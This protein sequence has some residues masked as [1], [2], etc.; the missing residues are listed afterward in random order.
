M[1]D[2][3]KKIKI[4]KQ[5][6]TFTDYIP[7]GAEAQNISTTDGDSVQLKLN[8]KPYYYNTVADMKA[9]IKLKAKDMAITL[10]Y[11]EPNDGGAA[12]YKIIDE[13]SETDYQEELESGLYAT[14]IVKNKTLNIKQ[15]GAKGDGTADD[16]SIIEKAINYFHV[17]NDADNQNYATVL[18]RNYPD[19]GGTIYFPKGVYC[20]SSTIK[21]P[22]Y[23]D[24]DFGYSTIKAISG[25]TFTS[26]YMF[27]VNSYSLNSWTY[28][29][30][31]RKG[32][33]KNG[34]ING[35]N[36]ENIRGFYI[37]DQHKIT[38][39]E[40]YRMYNSINYAGGYYIDEVYISNCIFGYCKGTDY[41]I[42]KISQGENLQI[43][44]VGFDVTTPD[45]T[46]ANGIK[47][48][49]GHNG[50]VQNIVNGNIYLY[51][52]E[53]I[54]ID[55]WHCE[56]GFFECYPSS[57]AVIKNSNIYVRDN[58]TP[59][60]LA[61]GDD[62]NGLRSIFLEN[63]KFV[64][65][66]TLDEFNYDTK[67]IDISHYVGNIFIKGCYREQWV[68]GLNAIAQTG[69][70][71]YDG[72]N[73]LL[74]PYDECRIC[75]KK[76]IPEHK[77]VLRTDEYVFNGASVYS[78]VK[79]NLETGTY[80]YKMIN[81]ADTDRLIGRASDEKSGTITDVNKGFRININANLGYGNIVRLYRGITS[82]TYT[83]YVDIPNPKNMNLYD[84]GYS[85]GGYK[86]IAT[87]D[88]VPSV[89]SMKNVEKFDIY[90]DTLV[91]CKAYAP[92]SY[93]T[94]KQGDIVER[95][96]PSAG[97]KLGWICTT[98]GTPG[99]WKEYGTIQQ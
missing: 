3:I 55:S 21:I 45:G 37:L 50:L 22:C 63:V 70:Q 29:Y 35:N 36:I 34:Y 80:Y 72:A 41:Q 5:D 7:I 28:A 74:N 94:W 30:V 95:V 75:N 52:V 69:I 49:N 56:N 32:F 14:L 89:T 58:S 57:N 47:I 12:T 99:T 54:V 33:I 40:F 82:G 11:Y 13:E 67:D 77:S 66:L 61:A 2:L 51:N 81:F 84:N 73:Y 46:P 26:N 48:H 53:D 44:N 38:G 24:V 8:K 97:G 68:I 62:L 16:T 15:L 79:W 87:N 31:G 78:Y 19:A 4:K 86:W 9:D 42:R 59:I 23:V 76:I 6:G 64:Y 90:T 18:L 85:I 98:S 91:R 27:S 20:I 1:A 65:Y 43:T 83:H 10:G 17:G 96:N 39:M 60:T 92:P 71:L 93:G 88:S 25:G